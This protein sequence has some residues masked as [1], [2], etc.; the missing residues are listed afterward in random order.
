MYTSTVYMYDATMRE[1]D[2]VHYPSLC[3]FPPHNHTPHTTSNLTHLHRSLL[4][5]YCGYSNALQD[6]DGHTE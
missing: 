4:H 6:H 2:Q 5:L 3:C 1:Y